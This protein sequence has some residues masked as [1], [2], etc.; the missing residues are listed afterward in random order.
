[1]SRRP[2]RQWRRDAGAIATGLLLTGAALSGFTSSNTVSSAANQLIDFRPGRTL[3]LVLRSTGAGSVTTEN[4]L[5]C[6]N[7]ATKGWGIT[8]QVTTG[9]IFLLAPPNGAGA[10][11]IYTP[12]LH[13]VT[14][15]TIVWRASDNHVLFS[16]NGGALTDTTFA[17]TASNVDS[18]CS[19]F[20]GSPCGSV[21]VALASGG[22]VAFQLFG[23]EA[24][25]TQAQAAS[26]AVGNRYQLS[27]AA[28]AMG[29]TP[30]VDF[31]AG[32]DYSVSG[33][34]T[35]GSAPVTF[36]VA[37]TPT[38]PRIDEQVVSLSNG[39][40]LDSGQFVQQQDANGNAYT[41]RDAFARVKIVTD[42]LLVGCDVYTTSRDNQPSV[43]NA[44]F[45]VAGT[46]VSS[47]SPN[48]T[49]SPTT[50]DFQPGAGSA[51]SCELWDGGEVYPGVTVPLSPRQGT[52][53]VQARLPI[54]LEDGTTSANSRIVQPTRPQKRL[55]LVGDSILTGFLVSNFF[56][57]SQTALLRLDFP[58]TGT[59]GV[60][61][62]CAGTDS[63][64]NINAT[65][66]AAIVAQ[67]AAACDGTSSNIIWI[68]LGTNDYGASPTSAATFQAN[69]ASF[70]DQLHAAVPGATIICQSPIQRI[71]PSTEAAN[72]FGNTLGDYR[73]AINTV[74]STRTGFCTYVEG[75]A[76]AIVSNVN[77]ASDGIHLLD[78]GAAQYK[79][80]IKTTLVY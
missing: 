33:F 49:G 66:M 60:A 15:I 64:N 11:N 80:F 38:L 14:R 48:I 3:V 63:L 1:M 47:Y 32:R 45:F 5:S 53:V 67:I 21:A 36:A 72:G 76:G 73:T 12:P 18:T 51:K 13:S 40:V 57:K 78:A 19:S 8:R 58:T 37:G 2:G 46:N 43:A 74:V 27:S 62:H 23:A 68:A 50:L 55:V 29:L 34:T 79:A 54:F 35:K 75:A 16:A 42:A 22:V 20:I 24:T 70:V 28:A 39:Y 25:A 77:M 6:N 41:I 31:D 10:A 9:A 65:G 56:T 71:A 59:G 4:V 7:G 44:G 30:I 52:F 26:Y 17:V 69:Y 61:T